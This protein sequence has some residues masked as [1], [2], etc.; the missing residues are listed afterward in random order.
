MRPVF[1]IVGGFVAGNEGDIFESNSAGSVSAGN[2]PFAV[3]G[4]FVGFNVGFIDP[5]FSTGNVDVSGA[6]ARL[7]RRLCRLEFRRHPAQLLDRQRHRRRQQLRR[8]VRRAEPGRDL[9][10]LF[11]QSGRSAVPTAWSAAWLRPISAPSTR[12]MRRARCAAAVAARSTAW[13]PPMAS[14]VLVPQDAQQFFQDPQTSNVSNSYCAPGPGSCTGG[15]P[16]PATGLPA[17]FSEDVWTRSTG[18]FPFFQGQSDPLP[19]IGDRQFQSDARLQPG[20]VSADIRLTQT[21]NFEPTVPPPVVTLVPRTTQKKGNQKGGGSSNPN[22]SG[23]RPD[24]RPSNIPPLNETRF[25]SN[26]VVV[27]IGANVP[28]AVL[29]RIVRRLGLTVL[30][31]QTLGLLGT[32]MI[33]F[34]FASG[35]NIRDIMRELE[36][37]RIIDDVTAELRVRARPGHD[38]A[39]RQRQRRSGAVHDRQAAPRGGAQDRDRREH[40]GRGD[41][42]GDRRQASRPGRAHRGALRGGRPGRQAASARHRH[43]GRHR[44]ASQADGHRTGGPHPGDPRVRR[45]ERRRQGHHRADRQGSRLGG[46]PEREDRQHELRGTQGPD[47]R[48]GVQGGA[49]T[50]TWC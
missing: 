10:G 30:S 23:L 34:E 6:T 38:G 3:A 47:P 19:F 33:Q 35:K 29:D 17:G 18:T 40:Q 50:G 13:S 32:R 11:D 14:T 36:K 26:Q 44:V 41:R 39:G 27:Q 21:V 31:S 22:N 48:Q 46:Q 2:G 7:R 12:P 42:L 25:I 4:G 24:G 5:S 15:D 20:A 28:P 45:L 9:P 49:T 43:G 37:Q 8:R 16:L 1:A